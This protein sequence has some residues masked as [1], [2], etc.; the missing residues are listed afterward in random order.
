MLILILDKEN[1]DWPSKSSR[2]VLPHIAHDLG[3]GQVQFSERGKPILQKGYCSISHSRHRMLIAYSETAIGIDLE[4][5]RE[6]KPEL[7]KR[8]RLNPKAPLEDW[9]SREAWIKLDDDPSHLTKPI[10]LSLFTQSLDLGDDWCCKVVS[11]SNIGPI[12]LQT[13]EIKKEGV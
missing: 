12:T 9:C 7:M 6:L 11:R 4:Y 2:D 8:L 13:K 10:P 5:K 1:G 3:W